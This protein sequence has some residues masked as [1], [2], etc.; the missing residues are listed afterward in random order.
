MDF[1]DFQIHLL[2]LVLLVPV[3]HHQQLLDKNQQLLEWNLF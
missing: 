2:V 3:R 1:Q